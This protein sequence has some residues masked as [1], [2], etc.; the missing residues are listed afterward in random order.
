MQGELERYNDIIQTRLSQ[1]IVERA[2]EVVRTE[3]SSTFL[4]SPFLLA[5]VIKAHL[6][7]YKMVNPELV[8]DLISGGET[9]KQTLEIK[10]TATAILGEA[11]FKLHKWNSNN[12][13][14]EVETA[15]SDEESQSYAKRQVG[16]RKGE[17]KLLGVPWDKEKDEI[18]VSFPISTAEPTKGASLENSQ[19]STIHSVWLHP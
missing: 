16:T 4:I 13:K 8:D 3:E 1:G 10:M 11:T 19:K 5:A 9:I 17:S 7:R 2:E 18:K 15:T 6:H 14:L 12:Q